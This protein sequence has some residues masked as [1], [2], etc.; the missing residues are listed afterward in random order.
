MRLVLSDLKKYT[1]TF[2][3]TKN[4]NEVFDVLNN[5]DDYESFIPFCSHSEIID[6]Q[7]NAITASLKLSF[8]GSS[9]EF[10]TQNKLK[11]NEFIDMNLVKGPFNSFTASWLFNP[12]NDDETQMTFNMKYSINN[13]ITDLIISKNIDTVSERIIEAFKQKIEA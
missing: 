12:I 9:S 4:I 7:D 5:V 8:L 3:V 2:H 10:I 11:R 6:E 1:R 13:P